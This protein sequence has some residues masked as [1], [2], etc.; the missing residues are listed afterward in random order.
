MTLG[1]QYPVIVQISSLF[2]DEVGLACAILLTLAGLALHLYR[3]NHRMM[4]EER[5]KDNKLSEAEARRQMGFYA[6]CA[7]TVT[8]L[9]AGLLVLAIYELGR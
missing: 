8:V 5:M 3:P 4:V 9:G 2:F 7:P 6:W 1:F